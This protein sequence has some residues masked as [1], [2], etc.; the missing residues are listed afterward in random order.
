MLYFAR[1]REV[2]GTAEEVVELEGSQATTAGLVAHLV[3]Q[4]PALAGVLRTSVLALNQEYVET[5][6]AVLL[7]AG[8]EVAVIPPLSGG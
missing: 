2:A 6:E 3:A 7:K 4:R 5:A 8:D 1:S